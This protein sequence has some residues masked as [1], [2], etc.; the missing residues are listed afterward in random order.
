MFGLIFFFNLEISQQIYLIVLNDGFFGLLQG[1][2]NFLFLLFSQ[3]SLEIFHLLLFYELGILFFPLA[4]HELGCFLNFFPVLLLVFFYFSK[5]D[6]SLDLFNNFE[7]ILNFI[8]LRLN[9][10]YFLTDFINVNLFKFGL[11]LLLKLNFSLF[12]E[13]F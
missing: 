7:D 1:Y 9:D 10:G 5:L 3:L 13:F 6:I 4:D 12:L 11:N 8:R 2:F